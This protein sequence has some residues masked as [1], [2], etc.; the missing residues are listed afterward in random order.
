MAPSDGQKIAVLEE[1]AKRND[2]DHENLIDSVALLV[3]SVNELKKVLHRIE[4]GQR[5][6]TWFIPLALSACIAILTT[7]GAHI[8]NDLQHRLS[9]L[10]NIHLKEMDK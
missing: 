3:E 9:R 1:K 5:F 4:G 7:V 8:A 2:E 10:E 6:A